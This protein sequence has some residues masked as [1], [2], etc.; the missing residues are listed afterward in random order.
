M[1]TRIT[2]TFRKGYLHLFLGAVLGLM[3]FL[4]FSAAQDRTK[5]RPTAR[6][7]AK[8]PVKIGHPSFLSPHAAPI[9]LHGDRVFVA[10]TPSDTVDVID[11]KTRRII[12]RVEVGIDPV[13]IAVRPDG[14]EVG[15]SI[16][17]RTRSASSTRTRQVPPT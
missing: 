16:T 12:A 2:K 10:N 6:I 5:T 13:S 7:G 11:A 14:K 1:I 8:E 9:A 17:F 4:V 3:G 15:V